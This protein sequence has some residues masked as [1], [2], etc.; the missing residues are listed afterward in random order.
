VIFVDF[1]IIP[2]NEEVVLDFPPDLL[3]DN[4]LYCDNSVSSHHEG[5]NLNLSNKKSLKSK[6]DLKYNYSKFD[7][8]SI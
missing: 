6:N 8:P 5:D 3:L 1:E 4:I 7:R 2:I